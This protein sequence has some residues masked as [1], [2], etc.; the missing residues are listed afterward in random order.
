MLGTC[1]EALHRTPGRVDAA[2]HKLVVGNRP[3][4][5]ADTYRQV[6]DLQ[7][8][9]CEQGTCD[10]R[11][12]VGA[13]Q[14]GSRGHVRDGQVAELFERPD[15]DVALYDGM[16]LALG[17]DECVVRRDQGALL[18]VD[19]GMRAAVERIVPDEPQGK[20]A[21]D[22]RVVGGQMAHGVAYRPEGVD[23]AALVHAAGEGM[24]VAGALGQG[25]ERGEIGVGT[26]VAQQEG[27]KFFFILEDTGGE[28]ARGVLPKE[29]VRDD[30][31]HDASRR[32]GS[33]VG[34]PE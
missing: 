21:A 12:A 9:L 25:G 10:A 15:V 19:K 13:G 30:R 2:V 32:V 24:A 31:G 27:E 33:E 28:P 5:L 22:A 26:L 1:G 6:V 4:V 16:D 20:G 11:D 29:M 23:A 18:R 14:E 34:P 17:A 8:H 7:C 3:G